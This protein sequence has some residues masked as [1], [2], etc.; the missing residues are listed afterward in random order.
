MARMHFHPN[1][2]I[3]KRL[4]LCYN[5]LEVCPPGICRIL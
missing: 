3:F 1:F 2:V 4:K 5:S